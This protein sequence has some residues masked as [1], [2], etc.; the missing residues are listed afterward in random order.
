MLILEKF[1]AEFLMML[2]S[3]YHLMRIMKVY[4]WIFFFLVELLFFPAIYYFFSAYFI[5][6][7]IT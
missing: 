7:N 4:I 2:Y 6:C 3:Q 1:F 5:T